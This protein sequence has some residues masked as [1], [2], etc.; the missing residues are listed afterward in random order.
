MEQR[1]TIEDLER[2]NIFRP[3][4]GVVSSDDALRS[5][6]WTSKV[7]VTEEWMDQARFFVPSITQRIVKMSERAW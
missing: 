5:I 3:A 1:P 2:K 7:H 6:T 4:A